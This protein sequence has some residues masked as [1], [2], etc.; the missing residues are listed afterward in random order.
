MEVKLTEHPRD[1]GLSKLCLLEA[2]SKFGT[3]LSTKITGFCVSLFTSMPAKCFSTGVSPHVAKCRW[4]GG[5]WHPATC[6]SSAWIF[7]CLPSLT[8]ML[9]H[10]SHSR[11]FDGEVFCWS[12]GSFFRG[13][14]LFFIQ[15]V[16]AIAIWQLLPAEGLCF[17]TW[18]HISTQFSLLI[19]SWR[20]KWKPLLYNKRVFVSLLLPSAK[21]LVQA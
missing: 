16:G 1:R 4:N 19:W 10:V 18:D 7:L 14:K 20:C 3:L 9:F 8:F 17:S 12:C 2:V 5:F 11:N 13:Y 21:Y 15:I 6:L